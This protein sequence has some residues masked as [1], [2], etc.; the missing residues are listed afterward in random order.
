[1]EKKTYEPLKSN[2]KESY[3]QFNKIKKELNDLNENKDEMEIQR[4]ID[5]I[6][7]Q[8]NEI[9]EANLNEEEYDAL[10]AQRE[11]CRNSEKIYNNLSLIISKII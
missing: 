2:Y 7:F 4:E 11:L 10:K 6:K 9:D 8:I 3:N 1:M 5:L